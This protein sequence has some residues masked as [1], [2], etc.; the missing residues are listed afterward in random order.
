[1]TPKDIAALPLPWQRRAVDKWTDD[2]LRKR[3][4]DPE[5]FWAQVQA[6]HQGQD[7]KTI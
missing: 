5:T 7:D 1:M 4:I 3:S 2:E 6:D